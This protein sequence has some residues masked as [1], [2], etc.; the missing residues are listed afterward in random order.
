MLS[1]APAGLERDVVE[2]DVVDVEGDVLLGLPLDR[3]GQLLRRHGRERDLL[4]DHGVAGK[5]GGV[6]GILDVFAGVQP[7]DRLHDQRRVHDRP[8]DD[9]LRRKVLDSELDELERAALLLL[10]LDKFYG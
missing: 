7:R 5:G 4:D 3:L 9:R 1:P 6:I 2:V 10:Q 8:V